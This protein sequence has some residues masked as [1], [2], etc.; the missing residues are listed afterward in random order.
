[1][2]INFSDKT[3]S[4]ILWLFLF[5]GCFLFWC[6]VLFICNTCL[7]S[8]KRVSLF[9]TSLC[10]VSGVGA[11]GGDDVSD[12][13]LPNVV[14]AVL[15]LLPSLNVHFIFVAVLQLMVRYVS[16]CSALSSCIVYVAYIALT[17][18]VMCQNVSQGLYWVFFSDIGFMMASKCDLCQYVL[19]NV[20]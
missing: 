10:K 4:A 12:S 8:A 13:W 18:S 2:F 1:M 5:L 15:L 19:L 17:P 11:D 9:I 14:H 7:T 3:F 6:C 16:T 20:C